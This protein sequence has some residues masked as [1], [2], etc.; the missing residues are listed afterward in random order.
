ME[1]RNHERQCVGIIAVYIGAIASVL[2][3]FF[4]SIMRTLKQNKKN[5]K[6]LIKKCAYFAHLMYF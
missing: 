1:S 4:K 2:F 5:H 3:V 6:K